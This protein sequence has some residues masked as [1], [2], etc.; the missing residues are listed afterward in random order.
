MDFHQHHAGNAP[1]RAPF[2][3][4]PFGRGEG[5][6]R[7]CPLARLPIMIL[8]PCH[9]VLAKLKGSH[10]R[11]PLTLIPS[12]LPKGRGRMLSCHL[13]L[14]SSGMP[15]LLVSFHSKQRGTKGKDLCGCSTG[16]RCLPSPDRERSPLAAVT[17]DG[18]TLENPTRT[19]PSTRSGQ[20]TA[21]AP[22]AC[23]PLG[24]GAPFCARHWAGVSKWTLP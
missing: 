6:V 10:C 21:R 14:I 1:S 3:P 13:C 9:A 4:L 7:G 18:K 2:L 23:L 11:F 15:C 22:R 20:G 12:P 19:L 16:G 24:M 5:G 17:P 8:A